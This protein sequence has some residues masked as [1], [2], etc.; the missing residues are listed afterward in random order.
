MVCVCQK[1]SKSTHVKFQSCC[2]TLEPTHVEFP[3]H[4]SCRHIHTQISTLW[5]SLSLSLSLSLSPSS[6]IRAR[7]AYQINPYMTRKSNE[8]HTQSPRMRNFQT[9]ISWKFSLVIARVL[10]HCTESH[11]RISLPKQNSQTTNPTVL[12]IRKFQHYR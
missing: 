10:Q 1:F 12:R 8:G 6:E 3:K 7:G 4:Q 5:V 9:P 11:T 2:H